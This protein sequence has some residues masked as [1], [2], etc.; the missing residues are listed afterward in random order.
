MSA[1]L[2]V[3]SSP[4]F[5]VLDV[6]VS[7]IPAEHDGLGIVSAVQRYEDG[8][9]RYGVAPLAPE[10]VE[11][12]GIYGEYQLGATGQ[13]ATIDHFWSGS[14]RIRDVVRV[15]D[16]H[17][18]QKLRGRYAEVIEEV[19][20]DGRYTVLFRRIGKNRVRTRCRDISARH[21]E[22]TGDRMPPEPVPRPSIT[23]THDGD[24]LNL[25]PWHEYD[26]L[27]EVDQY[28]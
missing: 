25:R 4:K 15:A 14:I 28:L 19:I 6:V 27:D 23:V 3:V 16:T 17:P 10:N 22:R 1:I 2:T 26:I 9:Y 5:A 24:H 18:K 8:S 20:P 12:G 21:L 7:R 11:I 13:R